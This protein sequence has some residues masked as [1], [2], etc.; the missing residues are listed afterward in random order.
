MDLDL[1][2]FAK[3]WAQRIIRAERTN[4]LRILRKFPVVPQT[5]RQMRRRGAI[6]GGRKHN[7]SACTP[8]S[9]HM[10]RHMTSRVR[11]QAIA[12]T[13]CSRRRV[14]DVHQHATTNDTGGS[15]VGQITAAGSNS[16]RGC[17][18]RGGNVRRLRRAMALRWQYTTHRLPGDALR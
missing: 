10:T 11:A 12:M 6:H 4:V 8:R 14:L 2:L 15:N 16:L 17:S 1:V 13:C 5:S 18:R 7:C 9:I 3:L